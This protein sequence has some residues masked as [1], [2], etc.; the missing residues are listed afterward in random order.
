[1]LPFPKPCNPVSTR[2]CRGRGDRGFGSYVTGD[3]TTGILKKLARQSG[4]RNR[5]VRQEQGPAGGS[6]NLLLSRGKTPNLTVL[7]A[8]LGHI[9]DQKLSPQIS[10]T[11]RVIERFRGKNGGA[12]RIETGDGGFAD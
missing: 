8:H 12:V 1:M 7:R 3:V 6:L 9:W 2:T 10:R 11:P 4:T 5:S